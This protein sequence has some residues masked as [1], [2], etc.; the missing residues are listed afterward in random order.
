V[1]NFNLNN[2]YCMFVCS[3][4]QI[5]IM[6]EEKTYNYIQGIQRIT[7]LFILFNFIFYFTIYIKNNEVF[8]FKKKKKKEKT[9]ML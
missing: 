4:I 6:N 7:N 5:F 3:F 1:I 9:E 2:I 8:F